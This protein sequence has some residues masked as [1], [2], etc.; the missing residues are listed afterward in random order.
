[1]TCLIPAALSFVLKSIRRYT[2]VNVPCGW[3]N[4][5]MS[6]LEK[7]AIEGNRFDCE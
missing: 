1:M 7:R 4:E 3:D 5:H 6:A 2:A